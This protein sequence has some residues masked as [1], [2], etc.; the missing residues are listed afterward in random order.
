V[1]ERVLF[2][3][4][5]ISLFSIQNTEDCTGVEGR[6]RMTLRGQMIVVAQPVHPRASDVAHLFSLYPLMLV[7]ELDFIS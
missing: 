6:K 4:I 2:T 1:R 5:F 7:K 3:Y